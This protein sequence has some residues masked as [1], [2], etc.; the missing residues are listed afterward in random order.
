VAGKYRAA[1]NVMEF[2]NWGSSGRSSRKGQTS[3]G[4]RGLSVNQHKSPW[5]ED[6]TATHDIVAVLPSGTPGFYRPE[7]RP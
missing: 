4:S 1:K 3:T 2:Y 6:D 5:E 7:Q